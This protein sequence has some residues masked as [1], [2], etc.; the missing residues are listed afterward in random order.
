[1]SIFPKNLQIQILKNTK[2][3]L[4]VTPFN[5]QLTVSLLNSLKHCCSE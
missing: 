5:Q 2:C 1:M 4:S 3:C